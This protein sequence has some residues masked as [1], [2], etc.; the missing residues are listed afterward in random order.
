VPESEWIVPQT[1]TVVER[2][3]QILELLA[4]GGRT[5]CQA[6]STRRRSSRPPRPSPS[7]CRAR[8]PE[9]DRAALVW[10]VRDELTAK[11]CGPDADTCDAMQRGG[12]R[13]IT[14]LDVGLQK[15]A[16]KWV[17][18]A[19]LVPHAKDPTAAAKTLGFKKLEPWMSNLKNK[20]LRNGAL[21]ALDYQTGEL[22][23]YVGSADYYATSTK[24]E[25]QPQYDVVGRAIASRARRSSRSTT[26]P[27]STPRR[28]PP[29]RC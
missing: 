13:V 6:T 15:I 20:D 27:P 21:V 9:L 24:P 25:F 4:A 23:A 2:R 8:P 10:A 29:G 3:N 5:R 7:S 14:T 11:L 18:A 16:E 1:T 12:L 22:L 19:A 28:S 17:K 26:S